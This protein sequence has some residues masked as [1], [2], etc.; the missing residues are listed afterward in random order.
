MTT[1]TLAHVINATTNAGFRAWV[2]DMQTLF[3]AA[4]LVMT[5]DTGQI[6]TATVVIGDASVAFWGYNIYR[7]PD[8]SLYFKFEWGTWT[9]G[10]NNPGIAIT[11]GE[12]SNGAGTLTGA[13]SSRFVDTTGWDNGGSSVKSTTQVYNSYCC[14]TND[15]FG[16]MFGSYANESGDVGGFGLYGMICVSKT[17]DRT[18]G[19]ATSLGYQLFIQ[20][21]TGAS[22]DAGP[23]PLVQNVRRAATAATYASTNYFCLIP[24]ATSTVPATAFNESGQALSHIFW[25][26]FP[27]SEPIIG[28]CALRFNSG[29]P[30]YTSFITTLF[31]STPHTYLYVSSGFNYTCESSYNN[32]NFRP[33][34]LWE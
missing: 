19:A 13:V 34:M 3:A 22:G 29:V 20:R 2:I 30:R 12:G 11:V 1:A 21:E 24:G 31:G 18:T 32:L 26:N 10:G 9:G 7:L 17:A 15:F 8:S 25:G 23:A 4:G 14:V 16:L 27:H 6:D 5:A 28:M 33:A